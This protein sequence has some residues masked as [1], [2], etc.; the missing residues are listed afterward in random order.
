MNNR[1]RNTLWVNKEMEVSS[2]S[3][4]C[5]HSCLAPSSVQKSC[6]ATDPEFLPPSA[7]SARKAYKLPYTQTID[8]QQHGEQKQQRLWKETDL[9]SS[10]A[11]ALSKLCDLGN[12][13]NLSDLCFSQV[14][15]RFK[16]NVLPRR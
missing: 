4:T 8:Q 1:Q 15:N 3:S 16:N 12:L 5:L 14:Q 6:S 13:T 10:S 11:F 7:V 9:S 2:T